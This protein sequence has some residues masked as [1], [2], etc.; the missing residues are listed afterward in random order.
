MENGKV[1]VFDQSKVEVRSAGM[2]IR[3]EHLWC[4]R[5][6]V[7][8]VLYMYSCLLGTYRYNGKGMGG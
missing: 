6:E 2:K 8:G 7:S 3:H 5:L 4:P 1:R